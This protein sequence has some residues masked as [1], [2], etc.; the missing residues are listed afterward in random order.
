MARLSLGTP[1]AFAA[2]AITLAGCASREVP[3]SY[4]SD[5]PASEK[6]QE[7]PKA[8]LT[9]ALDADPVEASSTPLSDAGDAAV[10]QEQAPG[11]QHEG[12][13]GHHH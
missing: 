1:H 6:A 11:A 2:V 12:H 9:R 10:A 8:S 5:S 7:A 13:H 3:A 4:P